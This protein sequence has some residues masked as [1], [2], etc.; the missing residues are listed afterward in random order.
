M[1]DV[2]SC[3]IQEIL[4]VNSGDDM[5]LEGLA[6]HLNKYSEGCLEIKGLA[7]DFWDQQTNHSKEDAGN[8]IASESID[9]SKEHTVDQCD[10]LTVVQDI[11]N[12]E[13][14]YSSEVQRRD[15]DFFGMLPSSDSCKVTRVE[16]EIYDQDHS[17]QKQRKRYHL[18][19]LI[20]DVVMAECQFHQQAMCHFD[21]APLS[22][23][24]ATRISAFY[25]KESISSVNFE[26]LLKSLKG[27]QYFI[28][29]V[30]I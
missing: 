21:L 20:A 29:P 11:E 15:T 1:C 19:D 4:P 23:S 9:N 24:L 3:L 30:L 16:S 7:T 5:I 28:L 25:H 13:G 12:I 2:D 26:Q 10:T 22:S 14:I 17:R 18:D 6:D 8:H 27:I